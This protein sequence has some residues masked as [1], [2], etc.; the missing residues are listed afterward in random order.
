MVRI[1]LK[2]DGIPE[3][4]Q[5][6]EHTAPDAIQSAVDDA[7]M[8]LETD[9]YDE[10][11][12]LCPVRTGFLVKSISVRRT[13]NTLSATAAADYASFVDE[14]TRYME[15]RHFFRQ[16]IEVMLLQFNQHLESLINAHLGG[17]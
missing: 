12:A 1:D 10:T 9:I 11:T 6:L 17:I 8:E 4:R 13:V 2:V 15:P 7:L 5:Y 16:P 3:V 14:G